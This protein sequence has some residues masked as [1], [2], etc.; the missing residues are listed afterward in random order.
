MM[1][2]TKHSHLRP[3]VLGLAACLAMA[4]QAQESRITERTRLLGIGSTAILDTYLSPEEYHGTGLLYRNQT[5][6]KHP[7]RRLY[8]ETTH[9]GRVTYARNRS[10]SGAEMAGDYRFTYGWHWLLTTINA[11][12]GTLEVAVGG[13]LNAAIGVLYNTR[14]GNNPAQARLSLTANPALDVAWKF[15]LKKHPFALRYALTAPVAG[16]MFSPNYGQSY[17]EIFSK[18]NYDHNIVPTFPG[19]SP[20]MEH[21][22]TLDFTLLRRTTVRLGY[23]GSYQQARPNGLKQHDYTHAFVIGIVKKFTLTHL[24]P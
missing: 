13:T 19:N 7:D 15:H 10:E 2:Q 16:L 17:Y 1:K 24:Q 22:L 11:G 14:N 8:R 12:N 20:S 23:L 21:L 9:Q 6:K 18:G 3:V 4:L 5:L